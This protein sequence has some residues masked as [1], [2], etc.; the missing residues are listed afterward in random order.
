LRQ[1]TQIWGV[2]EMQK[3]GQTDKSTHETLRSRMPA[4]LMRYGHLMH[5]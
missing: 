3:N 4:M 1:V 5:F 2:T